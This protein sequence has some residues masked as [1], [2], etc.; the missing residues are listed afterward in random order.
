MPRA[1]GGERRQGSGRHRL[2]RTAVLALL[3]I[4]LVAS[5]AWPPRPLLV[6]NVSASAPIGLY[7]VAPAR[8]RTGDMVVAWTPPAARLLAA[9]RRYLPS[10][11]PLVKRVR[12]EAGDL[13]CASGRIVMINGRRAAERRGRDGRNRPMPWWEGCRRL[14]DDEYL[15]LMGSPASFDGRYF[16]VTDR[17]GVVGR[18]MLLWERPGRPAHDA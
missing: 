16:G 18:A 6:W 2:R 1:E 3:L 10:N 14:A 7:A 5:I 12:A 13:V 15:L 9:R 4:G 11:I 8:P 17:S